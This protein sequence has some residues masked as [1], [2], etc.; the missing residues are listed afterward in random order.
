MLLG[1]VLRRKP[2]PP[3]NNLCR[4]CL[5][6]VLERFCERKST[7]TRKIEE[8]IEGEGKDSIGG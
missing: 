5:S 8:M 4:L 6:V 2:T 1:G 7:P 3:K